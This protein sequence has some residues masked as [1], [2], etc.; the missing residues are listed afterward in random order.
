MENSFVRA[1]RALAV[2]TDDHG[3]EEVNALAT[4]VNELLEEEGFLVDGVVVVS[5]D[6][7]EI[8]KA[9]ETGVVG[10]VD[11]LVTIGGVGLSPRDQTPEATKPLIDRP[12]PG[13]AEALRSSG[14]AAGAQDACLSRGKVGVSGS[15]LVANLAKSRSAVRDGMATLL[16]LARYVIEE[17]SSLDF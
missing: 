12:L 5:N 14:L 16:P 8:R 13:L 2:I 15:T 17:I 3:G 1:G 7:D 9:L 4:I 11:L 6:Q 10:G